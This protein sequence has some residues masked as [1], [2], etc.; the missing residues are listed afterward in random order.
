MRTQTGDSACWG[1]REGRGACEV[2]SG[3]EYYCSA[4][5][6]LRTLWHGT[7]ALQGPRGA[8]VCAMWKAMTAHLIF[9]ALW[10]FSQLE[11]AG[12]MS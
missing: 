11:L 1:W 9:S 12:A 2:D 8:A 5:G 10:S 7:S 3:S 4:R 6:F